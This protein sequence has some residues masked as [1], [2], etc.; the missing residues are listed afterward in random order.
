MYTNIIYKDTHIIISN[1]IKVASTKNY[2]EELHKASHCLDTNNRID[3]QKMFS[4]ITISVER[5]Q[6]LDVNLSQDSPQPI[7]TNPVLTRLASVVG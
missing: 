2:T 5:R 3:S 4:D 6:L 1:H 7:K